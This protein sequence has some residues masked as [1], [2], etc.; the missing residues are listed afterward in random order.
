MKNAIEILTKEAVQIYNQ[1]REELVS[2]LDR[3]LESWVNYSKS[4]N[5]SI[6]EWLKVVPN[7]EED[8]VLLKN[9]LDKILNIKLKRQKIFFLLDSPFCEEESIC[10]SFYI[11]PEDPKIYEIDSNLAERIDILENNIPEGEMIKFLANRQKIRYYFAVDIASRLNTEELKALILCLGDYLYEIY[12]R[13][14][15]LK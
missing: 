12:L 11:S 1:C 15:Y 14:N 6:E 10:R 8:C 2:I 9:N 5:F 4:K 13:E 7:Q 3:L